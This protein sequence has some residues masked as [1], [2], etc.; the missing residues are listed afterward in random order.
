MGYPEVPAK[1][2]GPA[3]NQPRTFFSSKIFSLF[4]VSKGWSFFAKKNNTPWESHGKLEG[5]LTRFNKCPIN[6]ID[7][8]VI[9]VLRNMF[10][11]QAQGFHG[12]FLNQQTFFFDTR[13]N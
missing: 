9:W 10:F 13:I 4:F 6:S 11:F 2:K 1:K 7:V 5:N 12:K 3:N 8:P